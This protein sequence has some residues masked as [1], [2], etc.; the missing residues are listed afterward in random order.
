[1]TEKKFFKFWFQPKQR[2]EDSVSNTSNSH[3][4]PPVNQKTGLNRLEPVDSSG[5]TGL[6]LPQRSVIYIDLLRD[7]E[8]FSNEIFRP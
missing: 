4:P 3:A 5:Q 6:N 2:I 7:L 1:M 8:F